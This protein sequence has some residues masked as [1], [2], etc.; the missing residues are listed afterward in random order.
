MQGAVRPATSVRIAEF[1][2]AEEG[3]SVHIQYES[4]QRQDT[5]EER[6]TRGRETDMIPSC[7]GTLR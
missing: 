5:E 4:R 2:A 3:G 1:F 7:C 6:E